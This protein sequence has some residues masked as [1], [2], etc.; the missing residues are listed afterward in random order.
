MAKA[1]R[2]Q[3]R[4]PV[5]SIERRLGPWPLGLHESTMW[6][7][8]FQASRLQ[9]E[10]SRPTSLGVAEVSEQALLMSVDASKPSEFKLV[11]GAAIRWRQLRAAGP[12]TTT[13]KPLGARVVEEY[14]INVYMCTC[15]H[16]VPT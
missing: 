16:Q 4:P 11:S 9:A 3:K 2:H 10:S 15:I 13:R 7:V 14:H 12:T 5:P 8:G 1:N 6:G